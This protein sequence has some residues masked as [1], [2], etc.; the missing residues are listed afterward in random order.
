MKTADSQLDQNLDHPV[1]E[2]YI[3]KSEFPPDCYIESEHKMLNMGI[4]GAKGTIYH[5]ALQ[6]EIEN[7]Y[8]LE[9]LEPEK[10]LLR[11][12]KEIKINIK[13]NALTAFK[14]GKLF[15]LAKRAC[16]QCGK[17]YKQWLKDKFDI[18]YETANNYTNIY[19]NCLGM[20]GIAVKMPLSI[21]T[22]ISQP[23]FPEELKDYLFRQ[24][25]IESMTNTDLEDLVKKYKEGKFEEVR[26]CVETWNE[27]YLIIQQTRY[28]LDYCKGISIDMGIISEK[29]NNRFGYNEVPWKGKQEKR[30]TL[31]EANKI[32]KKLLDDLYTAH[33]V[34]SAGIQDAEDMI[35]NLD[36]ENDKVLKM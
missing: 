5:Q 13:V 7:A 3:K 25:N 12:E 11:I 2:K 23:S 34:L 20:I 21:L 28:V 27:D 4:I 30:V 36:C 18:C 14:F 16:R 32:N 22:K 31:A 9:N 8:N 35:F 17:P 6:M 15:F 29:I 33:C 19:K 24:G 26:D 1:F 10:Q